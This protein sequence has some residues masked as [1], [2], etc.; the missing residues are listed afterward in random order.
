MSEEKIDLGDGGLPMTVADGGLTTTVADIGTSAEIMDSG[1]TTKMGKEFDEETCL[2]MW[3]ELNDDNDGKVTNF[4]ELTDLWFRNLEEYAT[5]GTVEP[6]QKLPFAVQF[7]TPEWLPGIRG[8]ETL[9]KLREFFC[10]HGACF[11]STVVPGGGGGRT[12]G[13]VST[14]LQYPLTQKALSLLKRDFFLLVSTSLGRRS[15]PQMVRNEV[16]HFKQ[17]RSCFVYDR[18][19]LSDDLQY[20]RFPPACGLTLTCV[21]TYANPDSTRPP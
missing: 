11:V 20:A 18:S 13:F 17:V 19:M 7:C 9:A 10:N 4:K 3:G 6:G 2:K 16:V 1:T 15:I 8:N 14:P 12:T 5:T 21:S